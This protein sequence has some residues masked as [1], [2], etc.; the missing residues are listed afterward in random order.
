ME[1]I[2]IGLVGCISS[3]KSTLLDCIFE[4][5]LSPVGID[6]TTMLPTKYTNHSSYKETQMET[7]QQ[8]YSI[9]QKDCTTFKN[10]L[11]TID[12]KVPEFKINVKKFAFK[13]NYNHSTPVFNIYDFPGLND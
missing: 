10:N 8:I 2:N 4:S 3:G 5:K 9:N 7:I 11:T 12:L 1:Y 13:Q 6:K